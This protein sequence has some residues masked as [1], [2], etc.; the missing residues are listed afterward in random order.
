[1]CYNGREVKPMD[2][3]ILTTEE[4]TP[5]EEPAYT[6]RP[7]WQVIGAWVALAV[8]IGFLIMYYTNVFR[9]GV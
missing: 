7:K 6:P 5:A 8:F 1:M 9:G 4:I 3:E 2:E